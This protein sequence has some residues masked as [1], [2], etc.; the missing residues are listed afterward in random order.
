MM[1]KIFLLTTFVLL[2]QVIFAQEIERIEG[3]VVLK[4]ASFEAL[5]ENEFILASAENSRSNVGTDD[6]IIG[7][8]THIPR[9]MRVLESG[10]VYFREYLVKPLGATGTQGGLLISYDDDLF[11]EFRASMEVAGTKDEWIAV[12]VPLNDATRIL[13]LTEFWFRLQKDMDQNKTLDKAGKM[14]GKSLNREKKNVEKKIHFSLKEENAKLLKRQEQGA[15]I[16]LAYRKS[17]P[18]LLKF[19]KEHKTVLGL[20]NSTDIESGEEIK[21]LFNAYIENGSIASIEAK[22]IDD[23]NILNIVKRY[24]EVWNKGEKSISPKRLLRALEWFKEQG[25]PLVYSYKEVKLKG[26][27]Q[28]APATTNTG[29]REMRK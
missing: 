8:I 10:T 27:D 6:V 21:T 28:T 3:K 15:G 19:L 11:N 26:I 12:G 24:R 4:Q 16:L 18:E 13:A 20:V 2:I 22:P 9:D 5:P 7:T 1:K 23:V 29:A 14:K 25:L 17:S